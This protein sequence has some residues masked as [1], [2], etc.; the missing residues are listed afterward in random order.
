MPLWA[1]D[2]KLHPH[3][4]G[5]I[6]LS[7]YCSRVRGDTGENGRVLSRGRKNVGNG[8]DRRQMGW[9]KEEGKRK[10]RSWSNE[11]LKSIQ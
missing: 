10:R 11:Q 3:G 5:Q 9:K 6:L 8:I 7:I 4:V 2:T 1:T